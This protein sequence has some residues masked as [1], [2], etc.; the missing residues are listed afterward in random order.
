MIFFTS[1]TH[2]N[3]PRILRIDRRPFPD[4]ASHDEALVAV[5]NEVVSHDDEVWHLGDV[6]RG[7]PAFKDEL[8]AR[9]NGRK[10][11]V[12]GNNDDDA[13]VQSRHWRSVQAYA[14]I[15]VDE[16]RLVLCHYAFR[17]WNQMGK[18]SVNLHGHSHGRLKPLPRQ[19]DVGVD[20]FP[21]RPVSLSEILASRGRR[22]ER[23]G[24]PR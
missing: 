19:Y 1:D 21:F 17:T 8:L 10:H 2:F 11:L 20:A 6:A 7:T 16:A 22:A 13:T 3:D 5:W 12:I 15:V 14:E 4:L 18:G 24:P 9:L 23:S